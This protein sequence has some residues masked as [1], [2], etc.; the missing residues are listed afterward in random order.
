MDR[1]DDGPILSIIH[2]VTI[3]TMLNFNGGN[4][5]YRLKNVTLNRPS[6]WYLLNLS[7]VSEVKWKFVWVT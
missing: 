2:T 4:N 6:F 1:M 7:V 3:D 5:R